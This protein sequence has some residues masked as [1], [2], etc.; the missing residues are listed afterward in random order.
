MVPMYVGIGRRPSGTPK[1]PRSEISVNEKGEGTSKDVIEQEATC[2][3]ARNWRS[4]YLYPSIIILLANA[5]LVTAM[6]AIQDHGTPPFRQVS[7]VLVLSSICALFLT[8]SLVIIR[9]HEA[10]KNERLP[11]LVMVA[12]W[13]FFGMSVAGLAGALVRGCIWLAS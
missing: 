1:E 3:G 10:A 9:R 12:W 4:T 6:V 13:L 2:C 5:L 8:G 11:K 7:S